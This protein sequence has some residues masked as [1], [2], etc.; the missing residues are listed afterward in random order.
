VFHR[1]LARLAFKDL[2]RYAARVLGSPGGCQGEG[3]RPPA[4]PH[5]TREEHFGAPPAFEPR[6]ALDIFIPRA[7][8]IQVSAREKSPTPGRQPR[9]LSSWTGWPRTLALIVLYLGDVVM[10]LWL[11]WPEP[12]QCFALGARTLGSIERRSQA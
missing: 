6:A 12:L 8:V 11:P 1:R 5:S 9:F 4:R 10:E 2:W 3:K 7:I